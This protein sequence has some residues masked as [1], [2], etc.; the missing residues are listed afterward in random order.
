M[1]KALFS[2]SFIKTF[3]MDFFFSAYQNCFIPPDQKNNQN[4]Y[5]STGYKDS[6]DNVLWIISL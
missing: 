5:S 1:H 4:F 6:S 3:S 2:C